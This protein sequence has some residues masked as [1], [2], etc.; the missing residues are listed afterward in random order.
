MK[1]LR[2]RFESKYISCVEPDA[3]WKWTAVVNSCGYG[4]IGTGNR[5]NGTFK[6]MQ[7]HRVSWELHNG[8][9]PD[10]LQVLHRCDIRRCVNPAHL[11]LGTNAENMADR[12]AKGRARGGSNCGEANGFAKFTDAQVA[13]ARSLAGTMTQVKIAARLG[14]SEGHV[15]KIISG[16]RRRGKIGWPEP[17][18]AG[19]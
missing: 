15:S 6:L 8:P 2:E 1:S 14:M 3:C 7:A 13:K 11:W 19:E 10:G 18:R 12:N 17:A 4:Q 5:S 9:I 16:S